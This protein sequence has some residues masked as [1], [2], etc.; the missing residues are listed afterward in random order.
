M[1]SVFRDIK[2]TK[3]LHEIQ[4]FHPLFAPLSGHISTLPD[5]AGHYRTLRVWG[6][7]SLQCDS[8][9]TAFPVI[10]SEAKDLECIH[11]YVLEIFR[12]NPQQL[13]FLPAVV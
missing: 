1:R 11:V 3:Y 9:K 13:V 2:D 10:Q 4:I 6:V 8:S 5:I 12:A 7:V